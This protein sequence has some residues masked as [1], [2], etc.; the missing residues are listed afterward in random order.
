MS[1][2]RDSIIIGL[3]A[4]V[5][6]FSSLGTGLILLIDD[7]STE[8]NVITLNNQD[9]PAISNPAAAEPLPTP[10]VFIPEGDVTE[11]VATDLVAGSGAT[12][13]PTDML[14]VHYHGT[15]AADG[16]VFDSSYARGEP[17][18]FP[19]TGVIPGWQE[20]LVGMQ[21]GGTRRL[22]I[23]SDLAYGE[24]GSPPNIGPNAALVFVVEL[25]EATSN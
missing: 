15:L 24:A 16:T 20:G 21:V 3:I 9:D 11:L 13:Q 23:P 22:E 2:R 1:K 18:T 12:V 8:D 7:N 5:M 4:A 10:D 14:T 17:A 19:L 6:I 25:I